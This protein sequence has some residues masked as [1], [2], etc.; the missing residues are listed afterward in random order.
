[1]TSTHESKVQR[2]LLK[3]GDFHLSP[4]GRGRNLRFRV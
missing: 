1:M 4:S 3:S 2:L